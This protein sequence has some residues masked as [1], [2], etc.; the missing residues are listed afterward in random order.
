MATVA[1]NHVLMT[2]RVHQEIYILEIHYHVGFEALL[3]ERSQLHSSCRKVHAENDIDDICNNF[4]LVLPKRLLILSLAVLITPLIIELD[5]RLRC[6]DILAVSR[7]KFHALE[8]I[9]SS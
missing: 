1:S 2:W 5:H 4:M 8:F 7:I 6:R 9:A 3:D